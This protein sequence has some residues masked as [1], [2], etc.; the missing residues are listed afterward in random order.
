M[1][2]IHQPL[3][4]KA[5]ELNDNGNTNEAIALYN[6]IINLSPD[7]ATPYYNLGLISKY[8]CEWEQS[9]YYNQKAAVL[10]PEDEAAWWN[11]G[12]ASTALNNWETARRSW[13]FFGLNLEINQ[14]ELVMDL[15]MTPIR[16]NPDSNPE[17]IWA[18]RIDPARTIITSVPLPESNHRYND[19][20]LNDGAPV[21]SRI[22]D[23]N[24]YPVFNEL[25]LL[26]PSLYKTFSFIAETNNQDHLNILA[27]L[28][29]RNEIGMEDWS[30]VKLLCKQCS[31]GTPH[32]HHDHHY[33]FS[34]D[35]VR[36]I[37]LAATNKAVIEKVLTEWNNIT[38]VDYSDPVLELE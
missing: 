14:D 1:N 23:G 11:L 25:Q 7:W 22:S 15:G 35:Q 16:L 9:F 34:S 6:Q 32:E 3:L 10:N 30:T 31:E 21:G 12:I 5:I 26:K 24:E 18:K 36:S 8:R 29:D 17:V 33:K 4:D 19:L 2:N 38:A 37:G 13:N 20:L 27:G 28:C